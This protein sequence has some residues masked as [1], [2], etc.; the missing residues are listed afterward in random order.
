[1]A[2]LPATDFGTTLASAMSADELPSPPRKRRWKRLLVALACVVAVI[3]IALLASAPKPEPVKVWF[4]RATN[5]LGVKKLVFEGT[6]S[7]PRE[8][9]V[10][11]FVL[12]AAMGDTNTLTGLPPDTGGGSIKV[13]PGER[14]T[15]TLEVPPRVTLYYV[16]WEFDDTARELTRWG[17][18]Q[19]GC[20]NFFSAHGMPRVAARFAPPAHTHIIPSSEIKE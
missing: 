10:F 8:I 13:P 16:S 7:I 18:L 20:Y 6:N 4:V 15:F 11:A 9:R 2:T 14:F 3:T 1:M 19:T 17:R 12:P 5:E